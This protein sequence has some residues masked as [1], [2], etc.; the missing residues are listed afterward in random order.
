[1]RR[2]Y[3]L[4]RRA[5]QGRISV[6]ISTTRSTESPI[7]ALATSVSA[8]AA[9]RYASA[10]RPQRQ[11]DDAGVVDNGH[12]GICVSRICQAITD[13]F[14][15]WKT[16]DL[17]GVKL[18]YLFLDGSHF[19]MHAGA[20]AEPVL[21]AWGS[22]A[23]AAPCCSGWRPAHTRAM[24]WAGFLGELVDRGLRP[25]LL[26]I[27]DGAPGLIGAVEIVFSNSLVL[28]RSFL[29]FTET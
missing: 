3:N 27:T 6:R 20:R 22:P 7:A 12:H 16:R 23:R 25:P 9:H 11:V 1:M 21:C 10:I 8:S 14:D 17:S 19:R 24:T 13:E 18:E 28:E 29:I 5:T 26:V 4:P 2:V 15:A